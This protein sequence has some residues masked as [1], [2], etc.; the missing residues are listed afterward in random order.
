MVKVPGSIRTNS[1]P[2]ELVKNRSVGFSASA[3]PADNKAPAT[4]HSAVD[5][6]LP[7]K[8]IHLRDLTYSYSSFSGKG[9]CKK[10]QM[11]CKKC[12]SQAEE[13]PN[14]NVQ[15][16]IKRQTSNFREASTSKHQSRTPGCSL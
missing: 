12:H 8:F 10:R 4:A 13:A 16:N 3:A 14:S 2:R 11:L 9:S 5:N 6:L 15:G 7:D 1:M